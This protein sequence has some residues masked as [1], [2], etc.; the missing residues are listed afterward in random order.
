MTNHPKWSIW[1]VIWRTIKMRLAFKT[2]AP[3]LVAAASVKLHAMLAHNFT[4][5]FV[6][7]SSTMDYTTSPLHVQYIFYKL[8]HLMLAQPWRGIQLE[9]SQGAATRHSIW[10]PE[11]AR[12]HIEIKCNLTSFSAWLRPHVLIHS[13]IHVLEILWQVDYAAFKSREVGSTL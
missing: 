4:C 3:I 10:F 5:K 12:T 2:A 6:C 8:Q 9:S 1:H 7:L 13:V 11:L